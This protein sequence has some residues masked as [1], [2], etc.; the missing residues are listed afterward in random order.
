MKYKAMDKLM[1][2]S[3]ITDDVYDDI[4]VVYYLSNK[5]KV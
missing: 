4:V 5:F 1:E 3:S 2:M